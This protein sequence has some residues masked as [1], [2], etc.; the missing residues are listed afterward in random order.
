ME[1]LLGLSPRIIGFGPQDM[2]GVYMVKRAPFGFE[3][4]HP[5]ALQ[6]LSLD[7]VIYQLWDF[8]QIPK[9]L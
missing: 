2:C 8:W 3:C 6:G 4:L 1:T 5:L 7:F 9:L